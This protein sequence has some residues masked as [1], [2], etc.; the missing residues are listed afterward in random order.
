MPVMVLGD[1][2]PWRRFYL[3]G[4]LSHVGVNVDGLAYPLHHPAA[5]CC[6]TWG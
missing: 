6:H 5:C 2:V 1:I 4:K 3:A